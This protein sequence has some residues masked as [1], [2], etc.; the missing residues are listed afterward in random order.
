LPSFGLAPFLTG[1]GSHFKGYPVQSGVIIL[2]VLTDGSFDP[3]IANFVRDLGHINSGFQSFDLA[4][5]ELTI[6]FQVSPIFQQVAGGFGDTDV[7]ALEPDS[8]S[9]TDAVDEVIL[10][11]AVLSPARNQ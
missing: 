4:E 10:F 9:L 1:A 11:D 7:I 2:I 5:K 6:F 8:H 3:I